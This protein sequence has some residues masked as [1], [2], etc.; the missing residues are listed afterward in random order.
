[1]VDAL[2]K[3]VE[4][5]KMKVRVLVDRYLFIFISTLYKVSLVIVMPL[6]HLN[7]F[8]LLCS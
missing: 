5:E 7:F 3:E 2:A 4:K 6:I 1:M 8:R